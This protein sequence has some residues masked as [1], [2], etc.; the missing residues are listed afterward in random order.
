MREWRFGLKRDSDVSSAKYH[1]PYMLCVIP[2]LLLM[3]ALKF[4]VFLFGDSSFLLFDRAPI[5][6]FFSL[7]QF[8]TNSFISW[9]FEPTLHL[10]LRPFGFP[11]YASLLVFF[12]CAGVAASTR[13]YAQ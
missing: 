2:A 5:G 3:T 6:E 12:A 8:N 10:V 11:F 9:R 1:L 7:L 4:G 13:E